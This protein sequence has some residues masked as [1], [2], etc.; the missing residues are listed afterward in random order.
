MIHCSASW[1]ETF[2]FFLKYNQV[3][4]E[5]QG[6]H[7]AWPIFLQVSFV[8]IKQ[9]RITS[10]LSFPWTQPEVSSSMLRA[11]FS[12]HSSVLSQW[13]SGNCQVSGWSTRFKAGDI[14]TVGPWNQKHVDDVADSTSVRQQMV[15]DLSS[16][17]GPHGRLNL[18]P[19]NAR[20][21]GT[22]GSLALRSF[23]PSTNG[24]LE[25]ERSDQ[26]HP[27]KNGKGTS[28]SSEFGFV[29]ICFVFPP[30]ML[31]WRPTTFL[32]LHSYGRDTVAMRECSGVGPGDLH[33][34]VHFHNGMGKEM[35]RSSELGQ[36]K[37]PQGTVS[38]PTALR[39]TH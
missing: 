7:G 28:G 30:V 12:L 9:L 14:P 31:T 6:R 27:L 23:S 34:P 4:N 3:S 38:W 16:A 15:L 36:K 19:V 20:A 18:S 2:H 25:Q 11:S 35:S 8:I 37:I 33:E 22:P 10:C 32:L 17:H 39:K 13:K 1:E 21:S 26:I 29:L 5:L 24:A